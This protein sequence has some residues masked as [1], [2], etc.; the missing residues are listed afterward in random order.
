MDPT[1]YEAI[2]K[3][4][5]RFEGVRSVALL[6]PKYTEAEAKLREDIARSKAVWCG[7]WR[8]D[9]WYFMAN[10]NPVLAL[11]YSHPLHPISRRERLIILMLSFFII[12]LSTVGV[13][14]AEQCNACNMEDACIA[15]SN[16]SRHDIMCAR[17]VHLTKFGRQIPNPFSFAANGVQFTMSCCNVQRLGFLAA[18]DICGI[19]ARWIVASIINAFFTITCFQ[20]LMCPCS[21]GRPRW[22]R[23]LLEFLGRLLLF[24]FMLTRAPTI[25]LLFNKLIEHGYWLWPWYNFVFVKAVSWS[26]VTIWNVCLFFLQRWRQLNDRREHTQCCGTPQFHVTAAQYQE[27]CSARLHCTSEL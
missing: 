4:T 10:E 7:D 25:V 21:L 24:A 16:D 13:L 2:L 8:K 18:S 27:Y 5:G 3:R 9:L 6:D 1:T 14:M 23:R 26:W 17:V 12:T 22:A 15:L 19:D 11:Y 20:L